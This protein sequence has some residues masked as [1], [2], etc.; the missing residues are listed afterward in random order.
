MADRLSGL[1]ASIAERK[2]RKKL[3]ASLD[4]SLPAEMS[5]VSLKSTGGVPSP[6][7]DLTGRVSPSQLLSS[8]QLNE[9]ELLGPQGAFASPLKQSLSSVDLLRSSSYDTTSR[10]LSSTSAVTLQRFPA[11]GSTSHSASVERIGSCYTPSAIGLSMVAAKKVGDKMNLSSPTKNS[12]KGRSRKKQA[13]VAPAAFEQ[14]SAV[15]MGMGNQSYD[16]DEGSYDNQPFG[17][18]PVALTSS[19]GK[20][21][22]PDLD[23]PTAVRTNVRVGRSPPR[24]PIV[25]PITQA[26]AYTLSQSQLSQESIDGIIERLAGAMVLPFDEAGEDAVMR[27]NERLDQEFDQVSRDYTVAV[28]RGVVDYL[29]KDPN[30]AASLNI[31]LEHLRACPSWWT[32]GHYES[33]SFRVLRET[34]VSMQRVQEAFVGVQERLCV[35][36]D[37]MLDL[38]KLW[39]WQRMPGDWEGSH[40]M[41]VDLAS[42]PAEAQLPPTY[43]QLNFTDVGQLSFRAKLPFTISSFHS[44]VERRANE[45]MEAL[46]ECWVGAAGGIVGAHIE[47]LREEVGDSALGVSL[48]PDPENPNE[49]GLAQP[50]VQSLQSQDSGE[51]YDKWY[52]ETYNKNEGKDLL[53]ERFRSEGLNDDLSQN[54]EDILPNTSGE[55]FSRVRGVFDAASTLM[56]RQLRGSTENSLKTF[57]DFFLRF[58]D[59]DDSG[60]SAFSLRL[61]MNDKFHVLKKTDP[62]YDPEAPLPP[63]VIIEPSLDEIKDQACSC[64]DQIISA[65]QKFPRPDTH[66]TPASP[67]NFVPNSEALGP[68]TVTEEDEIV[69]LTKD[70]VCNA[71]DGHFA[72]PYELVAK[73][74]DFHSLLSGEWEEKVLAALEERKNTEETTVANLE[75]LFKVADELH[76]LTDQIKNCTE[77]L[78][79]F[80]MFMVNSYEVKTHLIK[81]ADRLRAKLLDTVAQDNREHMQKM[82][83]EYQDIVNTLVTDPTDAAELKALQEYAVKSMDDLSR[84][85]DEYL[86]EVYERVKFLLDQE[87][88]VNR[89]DLNLFYTTYSWPNQVKTFMA[90]ST[91]LQNNRKR[92]LELVVEGQQEHLSREIS[93]LDRKVEKLC[94][95][96]S[97]APADVQNVYKKIVNIK[98]GLEEAEAEA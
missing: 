18:Q 82:G 21:F 37:V 46:R 67:M 90:K 3:Q 5:K 47:M 19:R 79:Y 25:A 7:K 22:V 94:E 59:P 43:E 50:S 33:H 51:E 4:S 89:E 35:C 68:C 92:D 34:G 40:L 49:A 78:N 11:P 69:L 91:D 86:G 58:S 39:V 41:D 66:F 24:M 65:A 73:F 75:K 96:G 32:N 10:L 60:D 15:N 29:I 30:Q 14:M 84:L 55:K 81:I 48:E 20:P 97:T 83:G 98:E 8:G 88:K 64:I 6:T 27:R 26:P 85:L 17:R 70:A 53:D 62:E 71:I 52:D 95:A 12:T 56:S 28:A 16:D 13:V 57:S 77:D 36:E 23:S 45:V 42:D 87:Y 1:K 38:E 61:K 31:N 93:S 54:A 9:Q 72:A 2:A 63:V 44:H 74:A 76:S 80:P